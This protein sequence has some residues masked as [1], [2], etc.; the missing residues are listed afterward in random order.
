M[1]LKIIDSPSGKLAQTKN[2]LKPVYHLNDWYIV[3][4][5]AFGNVQD[6][7]ALAD[8]RPVGKNEPLRTSQILYRDVLDK[9]IETRNSVYMLM[10]PY[11]EAKALNMNVKFAQ[12]PVRDAYSAQKVVEPKF[13]RDEF[14]KC[15]PG[16]T[17]YPNGEC[18]DPRTDVARA[19]FYKGW[20]ALEAMAGQALAMKLDAVV[21]VLR[22][23]HP[24]LEGMDP[25]L[26]SVALR[27]AHNMHKQYAQLRDQ[28][29]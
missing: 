23:L 9:Y 13:A 3:G 15:Y 25:F 14:K 28:V 26:D 29:G 11:V 6:R 27:E 24:T 19:A 2:G 7:A 21:T 18:D 1:E 17:F 10:N 12:T 5:V 8:G 22:T 20:L 4:A 16:A